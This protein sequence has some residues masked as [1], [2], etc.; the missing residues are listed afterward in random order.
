VN[1]LVRRP[2]SFR[3]ELR[4]GRRHW[5]QGGL[6]RQPGHRDE[7]SRAGQN[8][9]SRRYGGLCGRRSRPT[10]DR[11]YGGSNSSWTACRPKSPSQPRPTWPISADGG[12]NHRLD[13]WRPDRCPGRRPCRGIVMLQC[14]EDQVVAWQWAPANQSGDGSLPS[15][16]ELAASI[17][18]ASGGA[19]LAKRSGRRRPSVAVV[20]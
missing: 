16:R 6:S 15:G 4:L 2:T 19:G 8:R 10:L 18:V 11:G 14:R 3:A 13:R 20:G 7:L 9:C 17:A 5:N 1:R 12:R